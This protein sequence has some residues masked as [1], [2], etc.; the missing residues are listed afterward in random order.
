MDLFN[1][2]WKNGKYWS[3]TR[4]APR[5]E[6]KKII[7]EIQEAIELG[8]KNIILEAGTGIGKALSLD[9]K[10]PTPNG[11][12][13]MDELKVGDEVFDEK[14]KI[15]HVITK[16]EIFE[17]HDCYE[18]SFVQGGKVIADANHRWWVETA[19]DRK[20]GKGNHTV[21]TT[22]EMSHEVL[23]K[24]RKNY[25]VEVCNPIDLPDIDLP[26]DPYLLGIWLGDGSST[27]P[28]I[29]TN[30]V[31]VLSEFSKQG[32]TVVKY[33]REYHYGI[34][35]GFLKLLSE[36]NLCGNKHIP[37]QYF[38][39]S[40]AQRLSLIQGLMDSDGHIT[41]QGIC[42][43]TFK[44]KKLI[45]GLKELL[46]SIGIKTN[47]HECYKKATNTNQKLTLYYRLSFTT[48]LPVFRLQR[49]LDRLPQQL[50]QTQYRR[51]IESIEKVESVPTQC[52][53][54]D[55]DSHLFL[56]TDDFIPTH[57]SAI[58]TTIANVV[59][60]SYILTMT[61]QLQ[62]QYL[63]DFQSM[64]TEIKG[65]SNY[66]C[67]YRK[68]CE[69]CYMEDQNEKKCQDCEYTLALQTALRSPNIISNYDYLYYAGN[70]TELFTTRDLLILDETH[71]FEKKMMSL[72]SKTLNRKT[73]IR[74]YGIDI[75][76]KVVKGGTLK[77]IQT[78]GY[79][80]NISK[81]LLESAK[82]LLDNKPKL[83]K[84]KAKEIHKYESLIN[85]LENE[86][87]IIETPTKKEI[88]ND[89]TGLKV[90]FKPLTIADYS[91]QLLQFGETRLFLTGTLGNKDKFCKWI[92][93]DPNETY[94][95]Y[96]KSPFPVKHR[97]I[98]KDYIGKMSG[99]NGN[100]KP[101]WQN[102]KALNRINEIINKHAGEKGVIHTSS[103]QQAWWIKKNLNNKLMWVAQGSTREE[104]IKKF[105]NSYKPL[106]LIGAGLKDGVDF[107]GDKCRYQILFKMP[108]PSLASVQVN[109]RRHYDKTWYAYQTIMPLMQAYGRGIRDMDDYCTMYVLDSDFDSLL[110]NY[111]YL[112]NEYFLEGIVKI[113]KPKMRGVKSHD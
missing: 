12:T 26:I 59:D 65:R 62:G 87:W 66:P 103:N 60:D 63:D 96:M 21:I 92:G 17:N 36:N 5:P 106:I 56:C 52:I 70:Y 67:N 46:C 19:K 107:K 10:I 85:I 16:S 23:I 9:T 44:N 94:Y 40:Y 72:I 76:E 7:D 74:R 33:D 71:N 30:D 57:N 28:E 81:R 68:T 54:V 112:F 86:K 75:F 18:I 48:N 42:E 84:Q 88:L 83:R 98:K 29:T 93:I 111:R 13:T 77:S 108:F 89:N 3:L 49:H 15:C 41:K 55:S 6:Q 79:W 4:Y 38:R 78:P 82:M 102:R 11:F 27:K 32:F 104:T 61:N 8:F 69:D 95:I 14:G 90:E 105:E 1:Y 99:F 51:Y 58:A 101:N 109:I 113:P 37:E 35:V 39:S 64:L 80:L 2:N 47:I 53:T 31:E 50:R 73:I 34:R 97:P 43:I 24:G 45:D 22:E 100:R 91:E 20:Q 25:S 110:N